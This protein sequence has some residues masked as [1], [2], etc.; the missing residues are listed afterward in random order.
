MFHFKIG[1]IFVHLILNIL[2]ET[3]DYYGSYYYNPDDY[4]GM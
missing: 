3:D 1:P 2:Y 4:R